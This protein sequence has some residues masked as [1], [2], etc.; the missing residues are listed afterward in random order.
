LRIPEGMAVAC[1]NGKQPKLLDKQQK[2]LCRMVDTA[3]YSIS[4]L[5]EGFAVSRSTVCWNLTWVL[6]AA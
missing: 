4:D 3:E 5:A 6:V 2:Q 1:A